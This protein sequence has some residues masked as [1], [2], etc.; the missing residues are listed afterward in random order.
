MSDKVAMA[1]KQL[2]FEKLAAE[3]DACDASDPR[4]KELAQQVAAARQE[5]RRLR[6][7]ALAAEGVTSGDA[8]ATPAPV[9]GTSGVNESG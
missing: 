4:R 3:Y 1:E 5:T 2:E 8:V 7:A 9:A 6:D